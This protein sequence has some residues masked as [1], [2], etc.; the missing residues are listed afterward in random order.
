MGPG[1]SRRASGLKLS[2]AD[3]TE[4]VAVEHHASAILLVLRV[5]YDSFIEQLD[6]IERP[7][8]KLFA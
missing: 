3:N 7:L 5:K 2:G 1:R 6:Y 8:L 4:K